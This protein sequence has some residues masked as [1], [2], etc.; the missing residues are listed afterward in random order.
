MRVNVGDLLADR[1]AFRVLPFREWL[2]P[3]GEDVALPEPIEGELMLSGTGRSVCLSGRVRTSVGLVCGACLG[4]FRQTLEVLLVE[5]FGRDVSPAPA[6]PHGEQ[7]LGPVDF[8]VPLEP[9]DILDLTEVVRQHL[10]LAL[11]IAPRCSE[12]CRGLCPQCGT[13]LNA[14]VCSCKRAEI[15]PRLEPLRRWSAPKGRG[16]SASP[17]GRGRE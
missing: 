14:G 3:L 17:S 11:P 4:G 7:E 6:S 13:N 16:G 12:A 9:G 15:D 8:M 5:E 2:P 10:V 1:H